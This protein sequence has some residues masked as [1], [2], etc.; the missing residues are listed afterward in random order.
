MGKVISE[1]STASP[2]P[3]ITKEDLMYTK[4]VNSSKYVAELKRENDIRQA[5][6]EHSFSYRFWN[7]IDNRR[8]RK[9]GK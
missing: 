1:N 3:D 6:L 8:K 9:V 7:W 5:K 4:A 2:L